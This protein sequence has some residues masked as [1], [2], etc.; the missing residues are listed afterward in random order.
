MARMNWTDEEMIL[1]ADLADDRGWQGV[2][3]RAESVI[4]LSKLLRQ[5]SF[6]S[7]ELR[8]NRFRSP[9]SVAMKVNNLIASHPDHRGAGLRASRA[10]TPIVEAFVRDRQLMKRRALKIRADILGT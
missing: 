8:E 6:H 1:A 2:N 10:E 3:S 4:E 7:A 9:S 5:A